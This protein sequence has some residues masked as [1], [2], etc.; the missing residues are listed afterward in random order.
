MLRELFTIF[1]VDDGYIAS[2]DHNFLQLQ[3]VLNML[4]EIFC[5]MGLETNTT[6]T[7]AMVCMPGNIQIQLS[8]ESYQLMQEGSGGQD[9]EE[10]ERR[11][12]VCRKCGNSM[13]NRGLRQHLAGVHD[14]YESEV[15][16]EHILDRQAGVE[17]R[18]G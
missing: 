4:A 15:V 11:V 16:E 9:G 13:Q 7:Q 6:K 14:I 8:Q 1:Y 10:W 18:A 17:H 12:V 2:Q 3:P 5:R